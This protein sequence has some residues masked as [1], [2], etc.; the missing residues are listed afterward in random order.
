MR[1]SPRFFLALGCVSVLASCASFS[2]KPPLPKHASIEQRGRGASTSDFAAAVENAEIVYFPEDRAASAGQSEPAALLLEAFRKCGKPF[3]IGWDLIDATQQQ[4]LDELDAKPADAREAAVRR[5]ELIGS[6]RAREYCRS[7][8]RQGRLAGVRHLALRSPAAL[9]A[10]LST[11]ERLTPEEEQIFPR[12]FRSPPGGLQAYAER[13][14]A[15]REPSDGSAAGSYRAEMLREQFAAEVIVRHFR[16]ATP[17]SKLLVFSSE[18]DLEIGRG[19]PF[20]VAQK[21]KLR[22]LVFG[23]DVPGSAGARLLTG[24]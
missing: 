13:L 14:S 1:G 2:G 7:V 16:G 5:L 20:Y 23:P 22:Q 12:G 4:A 19:V 18:A 3:A 15:R 24:L 8:L 6:G 11:T 10:K 9:L 21:L 17:E